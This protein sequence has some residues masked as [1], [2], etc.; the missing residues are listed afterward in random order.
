MLVVLIG[1]RASGKTSLGRRLAA[2]HALQFIDLDDRV[3]AR[4][5]ESTV[6]EVWATH[7]EAAWRAGEAAEVRALLGE[8]DGPGRVVALGGGTPMIDAARG[9]LEAAR[10]KGRARIVYLRASATR[11]AERLRAAGGDRPTLT[12]ADVA[13]EA[14]G[15]LAAREPVYLALADATCDTDGAEDAAIAALDAIVGQ[16]RE[17][18][19]GGAGGGKA[20]ID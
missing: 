18:R 7:G 19:A 1:A 10:A 13:A 14:A 15:I 8:P 3:L 20:G 4:F 17:S 2:A 5:E 11:L 16:W 6:S 12:G 9:L